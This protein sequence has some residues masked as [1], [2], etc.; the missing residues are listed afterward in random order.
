MTVL[1][2]PEYGYESGRNWRMSWP[3]TEPDGHDGQ[4]RWQC[5]E[6]PDC[7]EPRTWTNVVF[8][9]LLGVEINEHHDDLGCEFDPVA[10][11]HAECDCAGSHK[12]VGLVEDLGGE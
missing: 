7:C 1:R 2:C 4:H 3:C 5:P 9:D 6:G 10:H 12:I 11:D 8:C